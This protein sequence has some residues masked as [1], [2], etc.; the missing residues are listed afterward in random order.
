MLCSLKGMGY[1]ATDS[2][3]I[4]QE[5]LTKSKAVLDVWEFG[6]VTTA[7]KGWPE[8]SEFLDHSQSYCAELVSWLIQTLQRRV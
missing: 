5:L 4:Q 8:F 2:T 7:T 3:A 6:S 1:H